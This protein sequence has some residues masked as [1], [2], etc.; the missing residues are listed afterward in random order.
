MFNPGRSNFPSGENIELKLS[1]S[2]LELTT[3][4]K[5]VNM[6]RYHVDS[7]NDLCIGPMVNQLTQVTTRVGSVYDS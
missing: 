3:E 5:L 7:K 4:C 1:S 6:A 2:V